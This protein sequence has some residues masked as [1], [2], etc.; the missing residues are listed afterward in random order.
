ML[1]TDI[2][3]LLVSVL[4]NLHIVREIL[5]VEAASVLETSE[6]EIHL[7]VPVENLLG[8]VDTYE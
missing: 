6:V 3:F 4:K 8:S 7:R 2:S 5:Y 1:I